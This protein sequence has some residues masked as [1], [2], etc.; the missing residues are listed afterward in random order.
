[1]KKTIENQNVTQLVENCVF[2]MLV[3]VLKNNN[4]YTDNE[5]KNVIRIIGTNVLG[6]TPQ[7]LE[8]TIQDIEKSRKN[9]SLLSMENHAL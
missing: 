1:M 2:P 9:E 8:V 5:W 4:G 7:K 3:D 6:H